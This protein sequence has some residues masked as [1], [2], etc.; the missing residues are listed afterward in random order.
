VVLSVLSNCQSALHR[1]CYEPPTTCGCSMD[2]LNTM[3]NDCYDTTASSHT[4]LMWG[5]HSVTVVLSVLSN[6]QSALHRGCYEPPTTCGC[7]MDALN[8]MQN[9]CYDTTVSAYT[10]L[11]WCYHS[12]T[13]VLSVLSNC[14]SALH[15]GCYEPPTTCG[16]SMDALKTMQNDCYD[17]TLSAYTA[18]MLVLSSVTVVLS[19]LSKCHDTV[20]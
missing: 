4:S 2:A 15:E 1:G 3:Q 13:V 8:T 19:V 20:K 10:A 12:V 14:Q 18:L 17:T 7:S 9:D 11:M 16:C 6:C 5:Y